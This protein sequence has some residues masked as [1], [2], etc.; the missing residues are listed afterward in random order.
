MLIEIV[1]IFRYKYIYFYKG[2]KSV[3]NMINLK[4]YFRIL[5]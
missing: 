1:K 2:V 5:I 4:T 3:K